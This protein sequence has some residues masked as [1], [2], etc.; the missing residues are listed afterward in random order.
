MVLAPELIYIALVLVA[1]AMAWF[2]AKLIEALFGPLQRVVSFIPVIGGSLA[3]LI[4]TAT[5]AVVNVLG[6]VESGCDHL[7]G[8]AWHA[9]ARIMDKTWNVIHG[10]AAAVAHIAQIVGNLISPIAAL[11]A[12]VHHFTGIVSALIHPL[13]TLEHTVHGI[14]RAI[15]TLEKDFSHGIGNDVLPQLKHLRKEVHVLE[16][17]TATDIADAEAQAEAATADLWTWMTGV[18]SKPLKLTFAGAVAVALATLGLGG[19]RC[20]NLANSLRNRG[21][22]LWSGLEDLLGLFVDALILTD[23]CEILPETVKFFGFVEGALTGVISQAANA[24]CSLPN[25]KWTTLNV[26]PGPQPPAQAF[27]ATSLPPDG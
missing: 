20:N 9:T 10:N 27:A 8:G 23:L 13:R 16:R 7:V 24:V 15:K 18:G 3:Y 2:A 1:L 26:V 19:L 4:S 14:D 12:L 21:C 17:S 22:G 5:Q 6:K 11:R 25:Q